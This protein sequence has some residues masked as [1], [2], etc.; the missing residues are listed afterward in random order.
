MG[1]PCLRRRGGKRCLGIAL[2]R[3]PRHYGEFIFMC[4]PPLLQIRKVHFIDALGGA[5][6]LVVAGM[7]L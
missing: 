2:D 1:L 4:I 7:L 5:H 6:S 3:R